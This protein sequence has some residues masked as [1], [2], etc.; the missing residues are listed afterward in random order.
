MSSQAPSSADAGLLDVFRGFWPLLGHGPLLWLRWSSKL[1]CCHMFQNHPRLGDALQSS[2]RSE[3]NLRRM[4]QSTAEC[5]EKDVSYAG[6]YSI[7]CI[8]VADWNSLNTNKYHPDSICNILGDRL[9]LPCPTK[10]AEIISCE[11]PIPRDNHLRSRH[12]CGLVR[13]PKSMMGIFL[14]GNQIGWMSSNS[15]SAASGLD[16]ISLE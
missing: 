8:T 1:V 3:M 9:G 16:R 5:N 13:S 10:L 7:R 11:W 2:S 4:L 12:S 6:P 15:P 14:G